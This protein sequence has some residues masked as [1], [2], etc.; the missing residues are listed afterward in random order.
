MTGR[1]LG[2]P[3]GGSDLIR[4]NFTFSMVPATPTD[5]ELK[6][7]F[8]IVATRNVNTDPTIY[9]FEVTEAGEIRQILPSVRAM[10]E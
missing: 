10:G 4:N 6:S 2:T 7:G 1:G 5:A 9:K 8:T 3:S